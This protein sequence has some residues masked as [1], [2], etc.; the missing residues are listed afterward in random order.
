LIHRR[1]PWKSKE[2]VA[3]ATPEW[4]FRFNHHPLLEPI[5]YISPAE[6]EANNYRQ[7]AN[8]AATVMA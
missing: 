7:L 2:A 4:V 6:A 1:A 5:G 8:Q 3:F